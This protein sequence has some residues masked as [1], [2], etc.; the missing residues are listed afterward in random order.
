[1]VATC[2]GN[3]SAPRAR[4]A[5]EP[6]NVSE[7]FVLLPRNEAEGVVRRRRPGTFAQKRVDL[8]SCSHRLTAGR[9]RHLLERLAEIGKRQRRSG[10]ALL[11]PGAV[12]G[13]VGWFDRVQGH[14]A[15][16]GDGTQTKE[17]IL[18]F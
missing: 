3:V 4:F 15:G 5:L 12:G 13:D 6:E 2:S 17:L 11:Q 18:A 7:A 1:M 16:V 10:G 14:A 8:G 9:F